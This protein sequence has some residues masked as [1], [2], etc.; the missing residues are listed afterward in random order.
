V[1]ARAVGFV[2]VGSMWRSGY[3]MP[4]QM[5]ELEVE[6]LWGQVKPLYEQLHCYTRRGLNQF[7]LTGQRTM[8][9]SA[10]LDYY[11]PQTRWPGAASSPAAL[12][13]PGAVTSR[14]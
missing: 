6:R 9:A 8:D 11:A 3:D 4:E 5:F 1:G 13:S 10:M 12:P 7:E 2:D 14:P